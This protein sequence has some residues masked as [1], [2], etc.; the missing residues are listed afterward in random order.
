MPAIAIFSKASAVRFKI[1]FF[2]HAPTAKSYS[3]LHEEA[4]RLPLAVPHGSLRLLSPCGCQTSV[5]GQIDIPRL[6][7]YKWSTPTS[8]WKNGP[9]LIVITHKNWNQDATAPYPALFSSACFLVS[10]FYETGEINFF[11]HAFHEGYSQLE[12]LLDR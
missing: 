8:F 1:A 10:F 7:C 9:I 6:V 12:L 5:G 4:I 2:I 3:A 11:F